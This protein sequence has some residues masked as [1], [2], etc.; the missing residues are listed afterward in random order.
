M[1]ARIRSV[2]DFI[3]A[4]LHRSLKLKELS[5]TACMSDSQFH[6]LFKS[7]TQQT[8]FKFIEALKM[9]KAYQMLVHESALVHEVTCAIGYNDYETFSRAFKKHHHLAP[10]DLKALARHV[11]ESDAK[12]EDLVIVGWDNEKNEGEIVLK[13]QQLIEEHNLTP[14]DLE[15]IK[16]YEVRHDTSEATSGHDLV[17]NKYRVVDD[18]QL[19]QRLIKQISIMNINKVYHSK[20]SPEE[21]FKA[22]VSPNMTIPPVVKIEV[23]PVINGHLILHTKSPEFESTMTGAFLEIELNRFLKYTWNWSGSEEHTIIE[24]SFLATPEGTDIHI[25]H[26]DFQSEES[27]TMHDSGWDHYVTELQKKM[28]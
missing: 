5:Q 2:L 22:W 4:N 8:P 1:D 26:R 20:Y 25:K 6:R 14:Q 7:N 10:D 27:R 9:A 16:A 24:V 23:N 28:G 21:L 13:L 17:K 11:E 3:E 19:W 18:Q 15:Q 12:V